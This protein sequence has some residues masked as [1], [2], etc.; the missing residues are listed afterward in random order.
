MRPVSEN[1][2]VSSS[3]VLYGLS[4]KCTVV[5][6]EQC[7]PSLDAVSRSLQVFIE[8]GCVDDKK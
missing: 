4:G 7:R 8:D 6:T 3:L 5:A 2:L 1:V